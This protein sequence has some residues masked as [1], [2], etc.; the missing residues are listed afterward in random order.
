MTTHNCGS[1]QSL[2][3]LKERNKQSDEKVLHFTSYCGDI[4]RWVGKW[5]TV[6]FLLR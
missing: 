4:F 6:C 1:L 5:I 2:Q 3:R